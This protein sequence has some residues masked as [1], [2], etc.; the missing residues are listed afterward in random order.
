MEGNLNV[1]QYL[2]GAKEV[3]K[4]AIFNKLMMHILT[5]VIKPNRCDLGRADNE[6]FVTVLGIDLKCL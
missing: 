3:Q 6:L 2:S 1:K 4:T 5:S